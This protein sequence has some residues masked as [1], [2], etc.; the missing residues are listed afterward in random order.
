MC[1]E[2]TRLQICIQSVEQNPQVHQKTISHPPFCAQ[3]FALL[4]REYNSTPSENPLAL[5]TRA[6]RARSSSLPRWR[7]IQ[8]VASRLRNTT[9]PHDPVKDVPLRT[10]IPVTLAAGTYTFACAFIIVDSFVNFR[11]LP[12][13]TYQ[14]VDWTTITPHF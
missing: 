9:K 5:K 13:S 10:L 7:R 2:S 12:P 11:A 4:N 1:I 8:R 6:R 3:C 14:S